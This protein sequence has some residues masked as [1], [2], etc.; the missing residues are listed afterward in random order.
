MSLSGEF[1]FIS[2]CNGA[3]TYHQGIRRKLIHFGSSSMLASALNAF[4]GVRHMRLR[5]YAVSLFGHT[6]QCPF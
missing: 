5:P 3:D 4:Q 2:A 1:H 6:L